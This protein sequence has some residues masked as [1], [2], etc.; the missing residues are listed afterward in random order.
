MAYIHLRGVISVE[1][2]FICV[3]VMLGLS[4]TEPMYGGS[5]D[6]DAHA[7]QETSGMRLKGVCPEFCNAGNCNQAQCSRCEFS[8]AKRCKFNKERMG[9]A[10]KWKITPNK[11][12]SLPDFR[13]ITE[14][15]MPASD[16]YWG[17]FPSSGKP[18][19]PETA[20]LLVDINADGILDYFKGSHQEPIELAITPALNGGDNLESPSSL[21]LQPVSDR[22]IPNRR[23]GDKHGH[24]IVDLDGDGLLDLLLACGGG[25]GG[26][27]NG[28][29][30]NKLF[31]GEP[32][33]DAVTDAEITIFRGGSAEAEAAG[34]ALT[35][36]RGRFNFVLDFNRDGLLDIFFAADRLRIDRHA[37]GSLMLNQGDRTW[38]AVPEISE[39]S[40]A[41]M[42]SDVDGDGF[43]N[44]LIV[45]RDFCYPQTQPPYTAEV[46]DF[47]KTRPVGTTAVFKYNKATGQVDDIGKQYA[48]ATPEKSKQPPCCPPGKIDT[49][50]SNNRNCHVRSLAS[51][52]F[53]G[54]LIAD[55]VFLYCSQLL[56]YFSSDRM[57]GEL[58]FGK[59]IIG[60]EVSLPAD[61]DAS[62]LRLFDIDNDGTE[63]I[64]VSCFQAGRY[65]VLTRGETHRNWLVDNGCNGANGLGDLKSLN[66]ARMT[67]Q[68]NQ[69][70]V[71]GC[72][73]KS[74][75]IPRMFCK[76]M[77]DCKVKRRVPEM[78]CEKIQGIPFEL[79]AAGISTVDLNNDGYLDL[80]VDYKSGSV[81]FFENQGGRAPTPNRF[82]AFTLADGGKAAGSALTVGTTLVLY[83]KN[84]AGC[85]TQFREVSSYQSATDKYGYKD[86]RIIF[87]LGAAGAPTHLIVRWPDGSTQTVDLT[88]WIY[89][90]RMQPLV[91]AKAS[92]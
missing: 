54:D 5:L 39:Y 27:N 64:L 43:A 47:C 26:I 55:Q 69:E 3:L 90:R 46:V 7:R 80:V 88:D 21:A 16:P 10:L 66:L 53:D 19:H 40:K 9:N 35:A 6:L 56:F 17:K 61:C 4:Y 76:K 86:D 83:S 37:P 62:A 85:E 75:R 22:I 23:L 70:I 36:L 38:K 58:P 28:G 71:D 34:I 45:T 68:E 60:S 18:S 91:I 92:R 44:E 30:A 74:R 72:N 87:G 24:N 50:T 48:A 14:A 12:C 42:V 63:E 59:R 20:P 32:G 41:L 31:W 81:Q 49:F 78:F 89:T 51:G 15:K 1:M 13:N 29:S 73:A 52:D 77:A 57:P 67:Q 82:I 2:L 33:R 8:C 25:L 11:A 79:K 65:V 84:C